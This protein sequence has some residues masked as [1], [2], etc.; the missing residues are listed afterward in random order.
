M[1][2]HLLCGVPDPTAVPVNF[3]EH[4]QGSVTTHSGEEAV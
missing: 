4:S 1:Y 2:S 3:L